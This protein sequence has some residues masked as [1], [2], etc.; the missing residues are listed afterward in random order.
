VTPETGQRVSYGGTGVFEAAARYSAIDLTDGDIR[1]GFQQDVT[2]GLNWYPEP[3]ARVM[4][5]YIHAWA[6]PT[7][8]S[9][10]GRP[11][12]ADIGQ[13]RIQIAF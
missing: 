12:E 3:Y 7:A 1:G 9:V 6:E 8:D 10:T 13:I 11:T 4:A 5:N 2:V